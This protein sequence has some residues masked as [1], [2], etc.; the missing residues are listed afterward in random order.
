MR[1]WV[2]VRQE[3]FSNDLSE[4]PSGREW[5]LSE[6]V[7]TKKTVSF[8]SPLFPLLSSPVHYPSLSLP[9]SLSLSFCP[10]LGVSDVKGCVVNSSG[11]LK[12]V[13]DVI[14]A[15]SIVHCGL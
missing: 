2:L 3:G 11:I 9:L 4:G 6:R 12:V 7:W 10:V 5:L 1:P 15:V 8:H 14:V 13:C